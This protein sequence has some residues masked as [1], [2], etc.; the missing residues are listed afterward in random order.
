[1]PP[2]ALNDSYTVQQDSASNV[3]DVLANDADP[4]GGTLVVTVV[5]AASHGTASLVNGQVQYTP[6][7]GYTGSDSFSYSISD[8]QGGSAS[9][10]VTLTVNAAPVASD[11][12]LSTTENT[13]LPITLS[14]T[15][16]D[17]DPLTFVITAGPAHGILVSTGNGAFIYT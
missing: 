12:T 17:G 7:S 10:T 4:D 13:A 9:A 14:A 6:S 15:D 3:L 11:Q 5:G 8:G 16:S 2:Q 1:A